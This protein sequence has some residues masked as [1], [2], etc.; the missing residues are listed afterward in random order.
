VA[1][2]IA[3]IASRVHHLDCR[4][5]DLGGDDPG[6]G[7]SGFVGGGEGREK[8]LG[9]FGL[10]QDPQDHF[11]HDAQRPFAAHHRREEIVSG[12][13]QDRAADLQLLARA[14]HH[15]RSSASSVMQLPAPT[16]DAKRALT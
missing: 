14:D 9:R 5:Q 11:G 10:S 2:L 3:A 7:G 8:G 12:G 6:H 13:I 1:A 4:R 15:L 16:I